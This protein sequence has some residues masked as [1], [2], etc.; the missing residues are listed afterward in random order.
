ML[1]N[2]SNNDMKSLRQSKFRST[3]KDYDNIYSKLIS[4]IN[5]PPGVK[6]EKWISMQ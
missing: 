1:S 3:K 2:S 5:P 4:V 6:G